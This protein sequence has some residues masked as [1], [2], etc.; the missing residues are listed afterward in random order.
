MSKVLHS[1]MLLSTHKE[2]VI[3]AVRSQTHHLTDV[4]QLLW[5]TVLG[6]KI[7]LEGAAKQLQQDLEAGLG[8]GRIVAALAEL[9]A[10]E[11]VLGPGELVEAEDDAGL[12]KLGADQVAAGVGHVGV[13]EPED[14]RHLALEVAE[15]VNG[16][17][18]VR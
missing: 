11:G 10:D 8:D 9:V 15:E 1:K 16:V 12:A 2:I 6:A 14:Q 18:A 3:Q 7:D 5:R 13:L 4:L 17:F